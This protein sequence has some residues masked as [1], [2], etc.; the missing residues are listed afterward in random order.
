MIVSPAR[1]VACLILVST[2]RAPPAQESGMSV[3]VWA[4]GSPVVFHLRGDFYTVPIGGGRARR[5]TNGT[6]VDREARWLPDG[7]R[8]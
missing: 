3:D 6:A 2:W 7:I 1:L 4:F 8:R 5:I